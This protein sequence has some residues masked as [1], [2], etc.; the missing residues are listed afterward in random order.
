M[1][2]NKKEPESAPFW[3]QSLSICCRPH[4]GLQQ[5]ARMAASYMTWRVHF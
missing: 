1:R 4:G 5:V 3:F 2:P